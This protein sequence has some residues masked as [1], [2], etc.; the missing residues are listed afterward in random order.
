MTLVFLPAH[1]SLRIV[2][3]QWNWGRIKLSSP[4]LALVD[5]ISMKETAL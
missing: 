5:K 3:M 2:T 1:Y 4:W